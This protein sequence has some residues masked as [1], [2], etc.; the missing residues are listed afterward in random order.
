MSGGAVCVSPTAEFA[1]PPQIA[2]AVAV[3]YRPGSSRA[4]RFNEV[5]TLAHGLFPDAMCNV[6]YDNETSGGGAPLEPLH[7]AFAHFLAA[8]ARSLRASVFSAT[9]PE[10]NPRMGG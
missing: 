8:L 3:H 1:F 2:I 7:L 10:T 6:M 5:T 9:I 4:G